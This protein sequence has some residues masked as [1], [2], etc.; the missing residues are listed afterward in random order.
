M[1]RDVSVKKRGETRRSYYRKGRFSGAMTKALRH[2]FKHKATGG[3][4]LLEL[5]MRPGR[6]F[7]TLSIVFSL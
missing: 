6:L 2:S 7:A 4:L 1:S 5:L 3:G